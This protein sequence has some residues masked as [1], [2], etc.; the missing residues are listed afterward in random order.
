M[1]APRY[2]TKR[3]RGNYTREAK[4]LY[5]R[6]ELHHHHLL[7]T[8]RPRSKAY[9]GYNVFVKLSFCQKL[10]DLFS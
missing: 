6:S 1:A 5:I 2:T 9:T 4:K 10:A 8:C 3:R 7:A